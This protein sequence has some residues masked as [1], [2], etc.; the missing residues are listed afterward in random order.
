M[1][2]AERSGSSHVIGTTDAR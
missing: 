2:R 1:A